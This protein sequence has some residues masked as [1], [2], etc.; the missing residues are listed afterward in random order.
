[1]KQSILYLEL[2]RKFNKEDINLDLLDNLIKEKK[3]KTI[4]LAA[5]L[6]YINLIPILKEYIESKEIKTIIKKGPVYNGQV[7]GC[8]AQAF[9]SKAD[10]LLLL[11]DGKF[12]AINNAIQLN[13]EIY[14]FN[15]KNLE[16]ITKEN[17]E[18]ENKKTR[19][20]VIKFISAEKVGILI[21]TKKGQNY[22]NLD[23]I[24]KKLKNKGKQVYLFES[25]NIN[26]SELDNFSLPIYINS[27][28]QGITMDD[29][30]VLNLKEIL[31]FL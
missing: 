22:N 5:T 11:T 17:I 10:I 27:A 20:K 14:V 9:D 21:S 7:L 25:D 23:E 31:E 4:S 28:C 16:K 1:M 6:Q 24:I 26:I 18:K 29:S 12:H 15:G 19:A 13:R 8:N 30:R 2:R 3:P